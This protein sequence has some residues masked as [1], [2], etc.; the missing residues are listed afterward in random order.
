M[1]KSFCED[2]NKT[3]QMGYVEGVTL[4]F[5]VGILMQ[6]VSLNME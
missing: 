3:G 2:K 6:K 5:T 4:N 1:K